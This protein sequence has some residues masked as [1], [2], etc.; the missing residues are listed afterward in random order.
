ME[1]EEI[2]AVKDASGKNISLNMLIQTIRELA[3][4]GEVVPKR[5]IA[6][7]LAAQ[8]NLSVSGAEKQLDRGKGD[9]FKQCVDKQGLWRLPF[10]GTQFEPFQDQLDSLVKERGLN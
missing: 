2:Q 6:R 3:P 1:P 9:K 8:T 5:D 7:S 4:D 10:A